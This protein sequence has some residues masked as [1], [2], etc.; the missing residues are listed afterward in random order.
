MLFNTL[1]ERRTL[2]GCLGSDIGNPLP[3]P[4]KCCQMVAAISGSSVGQLRFELLLCRH[5]GVHSVLCCPAVG[6]LKAAL[7]PAA[8]VG[9]WSVLC[10]SFYPLGR[11]VGSLP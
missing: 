2:V 9:E 3:L 10:V 11:V 8:L 4:S 7:G 6:E 1:S 5:T